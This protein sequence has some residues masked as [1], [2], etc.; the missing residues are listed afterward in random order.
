M[1]MTHHAP[2]T[3]QASPFPRRLYQQALDL[4][5]IWNELVV[6]MSQDDTFMDDMVSK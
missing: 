6:R 1:K 4:Q 3:L 5:P 2:F